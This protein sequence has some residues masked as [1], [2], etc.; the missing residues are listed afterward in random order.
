MFHKIISAFTVATALVMP[1]AAV[2]WMTDFEAA[3]AKAAAEDKA[4][5]LFFTGSD[6]CHFCNVLRHRVLDTPAFNEWSADKFVCVEIDLPA[7]IRLSEEQLRQNHGL[8]KRYYVGGYPTVV[9]IDAA[10][11]ALGGFTGGMTRL[12]D[13]QRALN[14]ALTVHRHLQLA[15]AAG[16]DTAARAAHLAAAYAAYPDQHRRFNG[17]L[18]EELEKIDPVNVTGWRA[19]Y[20]AEQQME[21]L[22]AEL[23]KIVTNRDAVL[24]CYD[25]YLAAALPGNRPRIL[26][27]KEHYLN[28]CATIKL[29][30]PR[31]VEDIIEARDLQLQAAECTDDPAEREER[32]RRVQEV[33][34]DPA[35]MLESFKKPRR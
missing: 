22:S 32:I 25:R 4:V 27:L 30:N 2:D 15:A 10:G 23:Q 9:V 29:R 18:R 33:F 31:T 3:R 26:R 34:A 11:H 19:T 12:P 5:L 8:V 7:R 16:E 1:A 21:A 6:W 13:V 20:A 35:A 17:W 14:G 28:G 24:A